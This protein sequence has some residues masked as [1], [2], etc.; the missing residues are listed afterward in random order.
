[1]IFQI[2]E[3][4]N[5]PL[6]NPLKLGVE[7]LVMG[8]L[9]HKGLIAQVD[10]A[11]PS[12]QNQALSHG[13]M[14]AL[15]M[16]FLSHIE[17]EHLSKLTRWAADMPINAWL[18]PN[19]VIP[20]IISLSGV[21][22]LLAQIAQ[23]GPS[24]FKA[25]LEPLFEHQR[26]RQNT[27]ISLPNLPKFVAG[28]S[29][30]VADHEAASYSTAALCTNLKRPVVMKLPDE[31][32]AAQVAIEQTQAGKLEGKSYVQKPHGA[33]KALAQVDLYEAGTYTFTK[34][35]TLTLKLPNKPKEVAGRMMVA[36][37]QDAQQDCYHVLW[38]TSEQYDAWQTFE[39]YQFSQ[40]AFVSRNFS[41]STIGC[42]GLNPAEFKRSGTPYPYFINENG[43]YLSSNA[44]MAALYVVLELTR[45]MMSLI[46]STYGSN[47]HQY[48]WSYLEGSLG[49]CRYDLKSKQINLG[50]F[51]EAVNKILAQAPKE[52]SSLFDT[53]FLERYQDTIVKSRQLFYHAHLPQSAP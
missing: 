15:L 10:Q 20:W 49:D 27:S 7:S 14:L 11:L 43:L 21:E 4:Q 38:T 6:D 51:E 22:Q 34:D 25:L 32:P 44:Q 30:V 37:V 2:N 3:A 35:T 1:M 45:Q 42:S 9:K 47:H 12:Q 40:L 18:E 36:H 13:E 41:C 46:L 33:P 29:V 26:P 39:I 52:V 31:L 5:R 53:A 16:T 50:Q 48:A 28:I 8:T 23:Y 17:P 24:Q 19:D